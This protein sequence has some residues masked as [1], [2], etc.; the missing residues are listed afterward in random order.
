[1]KKLQILLIAG[2][3]AFFLS[4]VSLLPA[5]SIP[6]SDLPPNAANTDTPIAAVARKYCTEHPDSHLMLNNPK[7][8]AWLYLMV[9]CSV[10]TDAPPGGVGDAIDDFQLHCEFFDGR[11]C[12]GQGV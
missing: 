3:T 4:C 6:E 7:Q 10:I 9:P 5:T 11:V 8:R 12:E 1:M 2:A